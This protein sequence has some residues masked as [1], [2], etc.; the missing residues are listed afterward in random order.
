LQAQVTREITRR[1]PFQ[2]P[3]TKEEV[4][5]HVMSMEMLESEEI[6]MGP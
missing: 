4:T 1:E 5:R 2:M 3:E 6:S